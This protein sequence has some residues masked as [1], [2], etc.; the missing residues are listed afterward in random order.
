MP[1]LGKEILSYPLEGVRLN[2]LLPTNLT[3]N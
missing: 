1:Q 3:R 2:A